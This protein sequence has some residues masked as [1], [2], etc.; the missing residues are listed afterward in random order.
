MIGKKDTKTDMGEFIPES[1]AAAVIPVVKNN[2]PFIVT[3]HGKKFF[4]GMMLDTSKIGGI[5]KKS[6]ND[7][8]K[9]GVIEAIKSG[10]IDAY[11]TAELNASGH[12]LFIPTAGT[13]DYLSDYGVFK[14]VDGY[15]FVKLNDKLEIVKHTETFGT[16]DDFR[17]IAT[18]QKKID[19]FVKPDD[20][21]VAGSADDPTA[22]HGIAA[23]VKGVA[24]TAKN[25][26][27]SAIETVAPVAS[28]VV[29]KVKNKIAESTGIKDMQDSQAEEAAAAASASTAT[30]AAAE[31]PAETQAANQQAAGNADDS[32]SQEESQEE[33]EI[34]YTETQILNTIERVIHAD[35]L[36]LPL[37]SEPFDQL[38]T[39]NNHL[40]KFELDPRDSYVSNEL[41]RMAADAN[42]DL[43]KLRADNL[44]M[45]RHKYFMLMTVR[46]EEIQAECDI[47]DQ[48]KPYGRQKADIEAAKNKEL[49][50]IASLVEKRQQV[51]E[52]AYNTR[53]EE[54]CENAS[55]QAR[56]DFKTRYQHQHN[57]EL[58]AVEG[59]IRAEI[60]A[61]YNAALGMLYMDRRNDAMTALDLNI[62]GV[63]SE[64]TE[65]Y[66]KMFEEENA[67][68]VKFADDIR[69]YAKQLHL[70]DAKRLAVEE[71]HLR[72]TNEVNDAR[73]EAAAKIALIQR[74]YETAQAASDARAEATIS[75]ANNETQLIKDQMEKRTNALE[76]DKLR[77]QQQLDAAIER[78]DKAQDVVKADYEHRL[79]Q[80]QDDRDSWKQTLES[81]KEQHRHNNILAAILVVAITIAA[82]AGGFVA[83]GVY[84][85]RVVAGELSGTQDD[86]EIKVINPNETGLQDENASS[87]TSS[88][89]SE[90]ENADENDESEA[91][92]TT[93]PEE[94]DNATTTAPE[95]SSR[96][97]TTVTTAPETNRQTLT[98]TSITTD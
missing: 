29:D 59:I 32:Q 23:Q 78:A 57:D 95:T 81:Y 4:I 68:Y 17:A 27:T 88:D 36:D 42:R 82:V 87:E 44:R 37:S 24:E 48:L 25:I 9:G 83:G 28:K 58:N 94:S 30:T 43:Q 26:A 8:D 89:N 41:N 71:E 47:E 15:E 60:M 69:E 55:R 51:I 19:E 75:Q 16:Y 1:V 70:D 45:L 93:A 54:A 7:K 72:I 63:L 2:K 91:V 21:I 77:L 34:V 66:K 10:H 74:E 18:G 61:N 86:V 96:I 53:L 6:V 22:P 90:S 35:N 92:A 62:T 85:N 39:L 64:L 67:L 65:D 5:N 73:A 76:Q 50:E 3:E 33:Q 46:I 84:W 49:S 11:V 13:M 97:G 31:P 12:I 80:A 98:S 40:I 52:E 38:F 79:I 14:R 20:V 56:S